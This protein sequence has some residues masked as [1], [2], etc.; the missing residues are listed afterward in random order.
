MS[1][2][3]AKL[4]NVFWWV[5]HDWVTYK[6][7]V[8]EGEVL[9]SQDILDPEFQP[10]NLN[11]NDLW[12]SFVET[13]R[14][15]RKI[16]DFSGWMSGLFFVNAR[17][18]ATFEDMFSK[19]G[20][21]FPVQCSN[22]PHYIVLIDTIIDAVDFDQSEFERLDMYPDL[23][24]DAARTLHVVIKQGF[25][26]DADIFR[27]GPKKTKYDILVSDA[28]KTRY[29]QSGLTGLTFGDTRGK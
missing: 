22:D 20:R 5:G 14:D 19:H 8:S 15:R 23:A 11:V 26:S 10:Y 25:T 4:N 28:F 21:A 27:C 1:D 17:T 6:V 12:Y 18:Y 24:D 9:L 2:R 16:A 7:P 13:R 29:E 3:L